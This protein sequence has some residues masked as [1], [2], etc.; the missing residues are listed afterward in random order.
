MFIVDSSK[1][2]LA[3]FFTHSV[4]PSGAPRF[5][6]FSISATSF[7]AYQLHGFIKKQQKTPAADMDIARRRKKEIQKALSKGK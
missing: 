6:E 4:S 7:S 2:S 5:S 1:R 3:V